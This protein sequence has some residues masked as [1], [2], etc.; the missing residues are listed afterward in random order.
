MICL[1]AEKLLTAGEEK[2][3]RAC[4]FAVDMHVAAFKGIDHYEDEMEKYVESV[5]DG[6]LSYEE[7]TNTVL[8]VTRLKCDQLRIL[9][10]WYNQTRV[11]HDMRMAAFQLDM[12]ESGFSA[13]EIDEVLAEAKAENGRNTLPLEP[14]ARRA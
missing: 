9:E 12:T 2:I 4:R 8:L 11:H 7:I 1:R 13:E 14:C 3:L 10:N 5:Y 6:Q